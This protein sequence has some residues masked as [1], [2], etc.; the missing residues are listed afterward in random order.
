MIG[1]YKL[2]FYF[3]NYAKNTCNMHDNMIF[4][5]KVDFTWKNS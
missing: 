3:V 1:N 5:V 2:N 4:F